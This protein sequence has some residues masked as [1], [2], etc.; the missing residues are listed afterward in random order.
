MQD[1]IINEVIDNENFMFKPVTYGE[2]Q[3]VAYRNTR[4]LAVDKYGVL[5]S[6]SDQPVPVLGGWKG[7]DLRVVARV[8]FE[9]D[10]QKSVLKI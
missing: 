4:Y 3:F 6:F 5:Y 1:F 7:T 9:G 10:W 8:K 2:H